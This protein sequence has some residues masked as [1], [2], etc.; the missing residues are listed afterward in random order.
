MQGVDSIPLLKACVK[1]VDAQGA[2]CEGEA[3]DERTDEFDFED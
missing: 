1:K 2:I 3:E